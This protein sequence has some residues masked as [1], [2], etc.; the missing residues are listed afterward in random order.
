MFRRW[1]QWDWIAAQRTNRYVA[2]S[3]ITQQRIQTYFGRE[4]GVVHP[5]VE[6]SRFSPGRVGEHYVAVSELMAHK[7]L[8][9]AV[10]AFNRLRLPLIVV[11]DGPEARRLQALAGDTIEFAG[12]ISDGA[13]AEVLRS[14][15][16]L[17]LTSI[18]EFGLV[19]VES[20]AAGRPVIARHGGGALETIVDG[21]TGRFW[22]GGPDELA[23]AIVEFDDAAVDTVACVRNA[24]RFDTARFR[25]GMTAEIARARTSRGRPPEVE[26]RLTP[27]GR[28][29]R[30]A[31][32]GL[33]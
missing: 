9:V 33:D 3:R 20:Q 7:Q 10:E 8:D 31:A 23:Q 6:I 32:R 29:V 4:A 17:I 13:V 27:H 14:A 11:G 22:S 1:R 26:R 28:R 25:A 2:N 19:A 24:A 15:R 18:E 5:P 16:A 30:R 12:R 21:V